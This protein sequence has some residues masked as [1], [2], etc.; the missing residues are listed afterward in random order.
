[1]SVSSPRSPTPPDSYW[2][3][4]LSI[5][6]SHTIMPNSAQ[7]ALSISCTGS[8]PCHSEFL[9]PVPLRP[10]FRPTPAH[11]PAS[12]S[13]RPSPNALLHFADSA[14]SHRAQ[15][16]PAP[17][18]LLHAELRP[19]GLIPPPPLIARTLLVLIPTTQNFIPVVYEFAQHRPAGRELRS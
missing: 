4:V 10:Q 3:R 9:L 8:D 6:T 13:W 17:I 12:S 1:M 5:I 19:I 15:S 2:F 7:Q 18:P 16:L 14:P 11:N